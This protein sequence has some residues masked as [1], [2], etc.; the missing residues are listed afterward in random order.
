MNV[1]EDHDDETTM[2]LRAALRRIAADD[3]RAPTIVPLTRTT[4]RRRSWVRPA[5]IAA[6][7]V[8][9]A[10]AVGI[11]NLALAGDDDGGTADSPTVVTE[12]GATTTIT[13][14]FPTE[15]VWVIPGDMPADVFL[16]EV[17]DLPSFDAA[18]GNIREPSLVWHEV[19]AEGY[20]RG[21]TPLLLRAQVPELERAGAPTVP[22]AETVETNGREV[23]IWPVGGDQQAAWAEIDGC[24][25][26]SALGAN[27]GVVMHVV[28]TV[29]CIAAGDG[30]ELVVED[31]PGYLRSEQDGSSSGYTAASTQGRQLFFSVIQLDPPTDP[32][33]T[34]T[35]TGRTRVQ[36]TIAG[37]DVMVESVAGAPDTYA[38][39]M[40]P[41][42]TAAVTGKDLTEAEAETIIGTT[43]VVSEDEWRTW[44]AAHGG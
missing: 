27:R 38:W 13:P 36:R 37:R 25:L 22:G 23:E 5:T 3:L 43:R 35:V 12:D 29:E 30:L 14:V 21:A 2:Q 40:G 10:G 4:A 39:E 1:I 31:P 44:A 8:L 17:H 15:R 28:G 41:G 19:D 20:S 24:G 7:V 11:A 18:S 34:T 33:A 32:L 9:V 42:V 16:G 6:G 26:V